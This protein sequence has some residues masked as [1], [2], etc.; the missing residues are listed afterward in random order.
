[1]EG[2][3]IIVIAAFFTWIL[4]KSNSSTGN[5]SSSS[6]TYNYQKKPKEQK[7]QVVE[8]WELPESQIDWKDD[9][10]DFERLI[11]ENG[12]TKLYH[13]TDRANLPSI[14]QRGGLYSWAYCRRNDISISLP[15]G[16][17][18]SRKLDMRYNLQNYVR[19]CFT[20]NHPMMYVAR[21]Q[22]RLNDPVVLEI[23]PEVIYWRGTKYSDMY[24]T[25]TGHSKGENIEDFKK[26]RFDVVKR[27][28]QFDVAEELQK[29][30]QAEVMVKEHIPLSFITNFDSFNIRDTRKNRYSSVESAD[31]DL[32]F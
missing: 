16:D 26:I 6:S 27:R 12:I 3:I 4:V 9:W 11:E 21:K 20:R 14:M 32:P 25:K 22:G 1:M 7:E 17:D 31:D 15:G 24:A 30:Y 2:I 5:S 23:D 29:Y 28:N 10:P 8:E 18:V 19:L 13:F